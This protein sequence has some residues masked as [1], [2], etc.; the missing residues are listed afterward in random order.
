MSADAV[1]VAPHVYRVIT[2]NG[3]VRVLEASAKAGDKTEMHGHPAVVAVAITDGNYR[4]TSPGTE[5][6]DIELKAGQAMYMDAV[7]HETEFLGPG[8]N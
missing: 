5:P 6:M 7:E 1:T 2:E 3:R 4:F 8:G